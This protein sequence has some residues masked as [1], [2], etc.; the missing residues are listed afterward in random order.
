M[1]HREKYGCDLS[2]SEEDQVDPM[3]EYESL[4]F[5]SACQRSSGSDT[6]IY[7]Y[8]VPQNLQVETAKRIQEKAA[9]VPKSLPDIVKSPPHTLWRPPSSDP[10]SSIPA[11]AGS[12][13]KKHTTEGGQGRQEGHHLRPASLP[14]QSQNHFLAYDAAAVEEDLKRLT[15]LLSGFY[16]KHNPTKLS[17]VENLARVF[18]GK[19]NVL[20]ERLRSSYRADLT[21]FVFGAG[22]EA[23]SEK[24]DPPQDWRPAA[25]LPPL[26]EES[27]QRPAAEARA[28]AEAKAKPEAE[29]KAAAA[30]AAV[31]KAAADSRV[32]Y[33]SEIPPP[34][35]AITS[36]V[37]V[38]AN[39]RR[40]LGVSVFV[41]CVVICEY[42]TS[43]GCV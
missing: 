1:L 31:E 28:A 2:T 36:K 18:Q 17:E 9:E 20:N 25:S 13:I 40:R 14:P 29:A 32:A 27:I 19:E 5:M 10:I 34:S 38:L 42:K 6:R 39:I 8:L 41:V 33:G 37:V 30:K 11:L 12:E 24:A 15:A 21:T 43:Y 4:V 26:T 35:A 16:A 23:T 7:W 22:A 3:L